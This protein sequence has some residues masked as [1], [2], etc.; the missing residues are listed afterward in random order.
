MG[1]VGLNHTQD[2]EGL[3]S[4]VCGKN[5]DSVD[6]DPRKTHTQ[7]VKKEALITRKMTNSG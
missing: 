1:M 7:V 2:R 3:K 5:V 4:N 6:L